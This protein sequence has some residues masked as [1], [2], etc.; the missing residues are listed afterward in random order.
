MK[1]TLTLCLL[2]LIAAPSV[3]TT[4]A[5]DASLEALERAAGAGRWEETRVLA[6]NLLAAGKQLHNDR[7]DDILQLMPSGEGE[8]LV[9]LLDEALAADPAA[10]RAGSQ[11]DRS[12]RKPRAV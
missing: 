10:R 6:D 5:P 3:A 2:V 4:S 12:I 1:N 9:R 11:V 7:R 8:S